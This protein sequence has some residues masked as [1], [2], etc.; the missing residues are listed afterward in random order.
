M[1][2]GTG[3]DRQRPSLAATT[4]TPQILVPGEGEMEGWGMRERRGGTGRER[5]REGAV[6][7]MYIAFKHI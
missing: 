3:D 6:T 4:D 1:D 5:S 2:G 7:Y